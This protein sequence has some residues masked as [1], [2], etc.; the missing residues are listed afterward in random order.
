M[1][2]AMCACS[3][4][5][6]VSEDIV[7]VKRSA[8]VQLSTSV[9]NRMS[10]APWWIAIDSEGESQSPREV[11]PISVETFEISGDVL[12]AVGSAELVAGSDSQLTHVLRLLQKHPESTA[13]VVG[14]TD[15]TPGPTPDYNQ[16]LSVDRADSVSTWLADHGIDDRR[17]AVDGRADREPIASNDTEAGRAANRRVVITVRGDVEGKR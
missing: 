11:E 2:L 4:S 14:H 16:Q 1:L 6:E 10:E 7:T 5:S 12:F 3:P 17:I 13:E 15:N 8:R 9:G